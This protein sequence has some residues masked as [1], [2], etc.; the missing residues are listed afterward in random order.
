MSVDGKKVR[1]IWCGRKFKFW[2]KLRKHLMSYYRSVMIEQKEN[3]LP[4][5]FATAILVVISSSSFTESFFFCRNYHISKGIRNFN[6]PC[7]IIGPWM[8][9]IS[10]FSDCFSLSHFLA[11]KSNIWRL[12]V[13]HCCCGANQYSKIACVFSKIKKKLCAL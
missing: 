8:P 4:R 13:L 2:W 12:D 1:C 6:H 9:H 5:N 11:K 3:C 7:K 10:G